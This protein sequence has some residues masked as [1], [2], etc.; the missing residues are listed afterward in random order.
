MIYEWY[1]MIF[2]MTFKMIFK[3]FL[4]LCWTDWQVAAYNVCER[5]TQV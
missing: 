1:E 3:F 2:E 4:M 5:V